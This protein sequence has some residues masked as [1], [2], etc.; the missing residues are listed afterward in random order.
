M[1]DSS[2]PI[3]GRRRHEPDYF[4]GRPALDCAYKLQEYAGIARRKRSTGKATWPGRKQVWRRFDKDGHFA[5]DWLGLE[6]DREL[7][8][9]PLIVQVMRGGRRVS[10]AEGLPAIRERAADGLSRLPHRCAASI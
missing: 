10:P 2:T 6:D 3:G 4:G 8:G 1:V 7:A 9:T 5:G